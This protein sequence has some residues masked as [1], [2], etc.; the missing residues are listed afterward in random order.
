MK[1]TLKF[2]VAMLLAA[3]LISVV[4]RTV[5]RVNSQKSPPEVCDTTTVT[6][7]DTITVYKPVP[8]DSIVIRYKTARLPVAYNNAVEN[9]PE[10]DN[11]ANNNIPD[12]ANVVIPI[13]QIEVK[14]STY[15][16]WASGYR[17]SI[18][19]LYV[20]PRTEYVTINKTVASKPK[21]WHI[22]VM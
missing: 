21:R 11:I 5:P 3:A 12:S 10:K 20:Y 14:D 18:D 8:R 1:T 19:S 2:I 13:S 4:H 6:L 22:G 16:V 17:V 15:H 9:I 7:Y